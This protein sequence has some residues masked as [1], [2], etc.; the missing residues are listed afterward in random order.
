LGGSASQEAG[1]ELIGEPAEAKM[2]LL[3][4]SSKAGRVLSEPLRP[5]LLLLLQLRLDARQGLLGGWYTLAEGE[6]ACTI[7]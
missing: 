2:D 3:L 5:E 6:P 7:G 1:D 4:Q